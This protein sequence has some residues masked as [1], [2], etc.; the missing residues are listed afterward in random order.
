M[1]VQITIPSVGESVQEAVLAEWFKSDGDG[2][3]SGEPVLVVETDK[4]TLEVEAEAAGVL[5]IRVAEG[6]TVSVGDVVGEIETRAEGGEKEKP[7]EPAPPEETEKPDEEA[8]TPAEKPET[9]TAESAD[10]KEEAPAEKPPPPGQT[11]ATD[12]EGIVTPSVR[13]LLDEAGLNAADITGTGPGGRITKNDVQLYLEENRKP[14]EDKP[15]K[16]KKPAPKPTKPSRKPEGE[17]DKAAEAEKPKPS[18]E[19]TKQAEAGTPDEQGTRRKKMSPIRR[20]IAS[21]LLEARQNTAM[22]TT[23]N[24]ID[25]EHV[26]TFRARFKEDFK[27]KY[28]VSLGLMS[29]FVKATVAALKEFPEVNAFVEGEEIVYHDYYHIGVAVSGERGLVVPVIR[30]VD[31]LGFAEIEQAI[32]DFVQKIRENRLALEELSGGTFTITNGGVFGSLLST[33]ILNT[34][35]SGILGMHKVDKRAV[36]ID[37]EIRIRPV[38]FV[39]L[40]YDH[41]IV[42]GRE[43]VTFLRRIKEFIETPERMMVEI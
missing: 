32:V 11:K 19:E 41:R 15:P 35:Q 36:V 28:G 25:M 21:R 38:M 8:E 23:F 2:V 14:T 29:F 20:R 13:R 26:M 7:A 6:E 1:S 39:A 33:P 17:A 3:E 24:E 5:R 27:K 22:L 42:D 10:S 16:E 40:S 43:A 37:D 34:P 4:V 31:R 18:S 9:E 12:D 30:N